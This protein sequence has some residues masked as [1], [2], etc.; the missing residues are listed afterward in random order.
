MR[1]PAV[2]VMVSLLQTASCDLT[3]G[4]LKVQKQSAIQLRRYFPKGHICGFPDEGTINAVT[5]A[6]GIG[7]PV[8]EEI[9][10]RL[11]NNGGI[12]QLQK[13]RRLPLKLS[14]YRFFVLAFDEYSIRLDTDM[15]QHWITVSDSQ[16]RLEYKMACGMVGFR[17][18]LASV[19][20]WGR[21]GR[22]HRNP[23]LVFSAQYRQLV[24]SISTL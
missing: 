8:I 1:F 6:A 3:G 9:V 21:D 14:P 10:T 7:K 4:P 12:Q 11:Q 16:T 22:A 24:Q 20:A 13:A 18:G 2:L 15:K 17:H 23:T 19:V 5:C